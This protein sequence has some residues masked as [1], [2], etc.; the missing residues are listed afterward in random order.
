MVSKYVRL[1]TLA[2]ALVVI[3]AGVTLATGFFG[4][5]EKFRAPENAALIQ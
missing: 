4:D 1:W 5:L 2:L 3:G